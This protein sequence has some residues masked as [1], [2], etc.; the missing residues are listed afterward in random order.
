MCDDVLH[1]PRFLGVRGAAPGLGYGL[2]PG[3]GYG[4]AAG[5]VTT[6][7]CVG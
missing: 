2:A 5:P 3:L 4:L 6:I 1:P 7:P